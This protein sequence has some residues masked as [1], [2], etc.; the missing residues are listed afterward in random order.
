[1]SLAVNGPP[2]SAAPD[3]AAQGVIEDARRRRRRRH[4]RFGGLALTTAAVIGLMLSLTNGPTT[5]SGRSEYPTNPAGESY[6]SSAG[7]VPSQAP[8]LIE[9]IGKPTSGS[10]HVMGYL[11]K[12]ELEAAS[13]GNIRFK[14]PQEAAAWQQSRPTSLTIPL[15]ARNGTTIIGSFTVGEQGA[16]AP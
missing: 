7:V 13:G 10:G 14:T 3:I 9:A 1:M 2:G 6:G 11:R 8:D 5:P 15:Y 16:G 12:S 4:A